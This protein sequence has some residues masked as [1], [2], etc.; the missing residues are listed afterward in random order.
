[1]NPD[2]D[3]Q[4]DPPDDVALDIIAEYL[5]ATYTDPVTDLGLLA[6]VDLPSPSTASPTRH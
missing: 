5:L 4:L 2:D 3:I 1:M 6:L